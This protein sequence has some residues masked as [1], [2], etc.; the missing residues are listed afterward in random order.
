MKTYTITYS[1]KE[2]TN[3]YVAR[4]V[5]N[6][7]ATAFGKTED[8]AGDRLADAVREYVKRWPDKRDELLDTP[9]R[10]VQVAD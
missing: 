2:V 1:L 4:C 9:A 8:E 7:M 10:E 5:T 3:G 6:P